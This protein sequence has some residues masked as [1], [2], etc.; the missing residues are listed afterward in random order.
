MKV[1]THDGSFH[2]DDAFAVAAL[3]LLAGEGGLEIARSRDP[4]ILAAA[5][6]RLDIGGR[7][8]PESNDF[9]HHQRGGA[10]ERPN[11][12]K[13]ASFGLIWRHFG[14]GACAAV[15]PASSDVDLLAERVDVTLVQGIDAG[16][17]GQNISE[18]LIAD[19]RELGLPGAIGAFNPSWDAEASAGEYDEAFE[20][21]VAFARGVLEREI[22]S[23][24][25]WLRARQLVSKAIA[26]AVDPRL[27]ELP[28]KLPWM[29]SVDEEAP[30]AL[31]VIYPKEDGWGLQAVRREPASFATKRPLPAAWAGL[32]GPGLAEVSGVDDA[33][34]CHSARF[35]AVASSRKGVIALF[36]A[37]LACKEGDEDPR[38]S[39][40]AA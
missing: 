34:F 12:I 9:D 8:D 25:A 2:A 28:R 32:S 10:G 37:A 11:G 20:R 14:A 26:E 35:F 33:I 27:I 1:A 4:G 18:P 39:A 5:D 21:A 17:S 31:Y 23:A 36:A 13:L 38:T 40:S 29:E 3:A 16:D 6:L 7:Y 19:V 24:A 22:A 15:S 30:R